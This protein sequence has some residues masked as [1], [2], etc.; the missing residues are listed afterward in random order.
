MK[1]AGSSLDAEV[2]EVAADNLGSQATAD[3]W[4]QRFGLSISKPGARSILR[5]YGYEG[6]A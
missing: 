6:Q 2:A 4:V 5:A 3:R 1:L